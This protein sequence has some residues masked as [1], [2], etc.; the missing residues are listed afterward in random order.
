MALIKCPECGKDV[1]DKASVCIHCGYPIEEFV[2][3]NL[4]GVPTADEILV[5]ENFGEN[6]SN[7]IDL[8]VAVNNDTQNT[9]NPN[10]AKKSK[11]KWLIIFI[12]G[13]I[14][15]VT[16][17]FFKQNIRNNNGK[18]AKAAQAIAY[19]EEG[20]YKQALDIKNALNQ[21]ELLKGYVSKIVLMG[22]L[23]QYSENYD[24]PYTCL[25]YFV[26]NYD[27]F[28]KLGLIDKTDYIVSEYAQKV[29]NKN[30][31]VAAFFEQSIEDKQA[32]QM[33]EPLLSS[34]T[35]K[36][37]EVMKNIND[38]VDYNLAKKEYEKQQREEEEEAEKKY[39]ELFPV[40]VST[41]E[42]DVTYNRG[43]YYCNG[44]VHNVSSSTHYYVKVKVTYYDSNDTVLT[45]DWTYAV[46]SEGIRGGENQQFEIMTKVNGS[47]DKYRVE[48]LDWD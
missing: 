48:V 27:E 30:V 46:G 3:N 8:N 42:C 14:V 2:N 32:C 35:E 39:N 33:L 22:N 43:Y 12:V 6:V 47:V 38:G 18:Q 5:Q 45:T 1:S 16:L 7:Q 24:N 36:M 17:A 40:Q 44:T 9:Y 25:L 37:L 4:I 13:L 15:F 11:V 23:T 28:E 26:G 10:K 34:N 29:A 19:F 21:D 31:N 41:K 20:K